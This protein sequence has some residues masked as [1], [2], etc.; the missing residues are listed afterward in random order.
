MFDLWRSRADISYGLS[1]LTLLEIWVGNPP[2]Y[3][4]VKTFARLWKYKVY[5]SVSGSSCGSFDY[6]GTELAAVAKELKRVVRLHHRQAWSLFLKIQV[7]R[8]CG[9]T[10]LVHKLNQE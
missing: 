9:N 10:S 7:Y 2:H 1:N 8:L 3:H 4:D 5:V 6:D